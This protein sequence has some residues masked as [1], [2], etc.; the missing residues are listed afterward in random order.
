MRLLALVLLAI[1]LMAIESSLA[2]LLGG[3]RMRVDVAVVMVAFIGQRFAGP[4]GALGAF[5]VGYGLDVMTGQPTWLC[6]FLAVLLWLC[7]RAAVTVLD[8]QSRWTNLV[9]VAFGVVVFHAMTFAF[10]WLT[11][12]INATRPGALAS[13]PLQVGIT[14]AVAIVLWPILRA[15]AGTG[16]VEEIGFRRSR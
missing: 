10:T 16:V 9:L 5:A 12:P 4:S 11:S 2:G 6:V 8:A 13:I 14:C 3:D 15:V 7:A 1:V